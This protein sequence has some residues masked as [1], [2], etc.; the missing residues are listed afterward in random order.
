MYI[1][2]SFWFLPSSSVIMTMPAAHGTW[3]SPN[4]Q[5]KHRLQ[6][7]QNKIIRS[8]LDLSLRSHVGFEEFHMVNWLPVK[9]RVHQNIVNHMFR[10]L[11]GKSPN[12]LQDGISKSSTIHRYSTRSGALALYQPRMGTHGQ[13][14]FVYNGIK[15]WNSLPSS[16]QSQQ[17][18]D[19]FKREV[20]GTL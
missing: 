13:K 14:T 2:K 4:K 7:T 20:K 10:I 9:Y 16:V 8:V 17:C 18:K 11:N 3:H 12:Y 5:T 6:T 1:L 15:L 19:I